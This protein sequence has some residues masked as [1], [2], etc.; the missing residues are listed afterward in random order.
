MLKKLTQ[1]I[2][3]A[4]EISLSLPM[5]N[6]QYVIMTDASFY[7]AG[8]VLLIED[9]TQTANGTSEHKI[10]AP[11]S[12][13]SRI[14]KPNQLKMSIYAKEFLA[15]HFALDVCK[16]LLGMRETSTSPNRQQSCHQILSN[17]DHSTNAVERI[18]SRL[19][20]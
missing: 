14:F 20:F 8:F 19:E 13:G 3:S 6:R 5:T 9:Y 16:H 10:Y 11:V 15:V 1:D 18:R 12:V 2:Q 7:A 17:K 4:C